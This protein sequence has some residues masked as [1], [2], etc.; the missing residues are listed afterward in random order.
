MRSVVCI[1]CILHTVG[2]YRAR[3]VS[4]LGLYAC[5]VNFC[6][7]VDIDR[8]SGLCAYIYYERVVIGTRICTS[9]YVG[10]N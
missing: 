7:H 2:S 3:S 5:R 10:K 9:L 8:V 6:L 1:L 4:S